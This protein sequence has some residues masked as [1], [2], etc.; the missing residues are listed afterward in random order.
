M[1]RK[2]FLQSTAAVIGS[3]LLPSIS[4]AIETKKKSIRFAHLTDIHVSTGIVQETGMAKALQHAQQQK[5]V[6]P[7][8]SG[9]GVPSSVTST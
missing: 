6:S 2:A 3:S 7:S 4:N 8:K 9:S 5:V 1:K